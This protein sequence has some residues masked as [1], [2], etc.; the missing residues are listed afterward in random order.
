MEEKKSR[1]RPIKNKIKPI[2]ATAEQ[3]AKAIFH[4]ADKKIPKPIKRPDK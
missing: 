3:I 2:P 1:G 4:E